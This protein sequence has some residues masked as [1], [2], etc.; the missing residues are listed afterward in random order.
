MMINPAPISSLSL[1]TALM[2][3][4]FIGCLAALFTYDTIAWAFRFI[5]GFLDRNSNKSGGSDD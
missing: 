4:V 1:A 2:W 3:A 5:A